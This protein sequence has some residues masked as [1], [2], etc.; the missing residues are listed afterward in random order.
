MATLEEIREGIAANLQPLPGVQVSAY[1][2]GA[3]TLPCVEVFPASKAIEYDKS[4]QR[5][6]DRWYLKVRAFTGGATDIG[7]QKRL[8]VMIASSGP[9]S[10]K[11]LIESDPQLGG[12]V[13]DLRVTQCSG[14]KTYER[15]SGPMVLGAE[16]DVEVW[17]DGVN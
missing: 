4:F 15:P 17:A 2:L 3:P 5:G 16:W 6:F 13:T 8:D 7:A 10:V 11:T 1:Q 9:G 12:A 14:Y